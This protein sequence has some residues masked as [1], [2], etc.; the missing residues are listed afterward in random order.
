MAGSRPGRVGP[1]EHPYAGAPAQ[2]SALPYARGSTASGA[3]PPS[4]QAGRDAA[5]MPRP[6]PVP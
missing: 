4:A 3:L 1:A 5:W 2:P 6:V